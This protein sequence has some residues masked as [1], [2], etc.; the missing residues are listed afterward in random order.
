MVK[1]AFSSGNNPVL[2]TFCNPGRYAINESLDSAETKH[3]K[4]EN[5]T[6]RADELKEFSVRAIQI[7]SNAQQ[8]A[9]I[10]NILK[11][12]YDYYT[13]G[14]IICNLNEILKDGY[15]KEKPIGNVISSLAYMNNYA[16]KKLNPNKTTNYEL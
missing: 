16:N 14:V 2:F 11:D 9:E 3:Q 13:N 15:G 1:S 5:I 10:I 7:A 4:V 6:K 12:F 8:I